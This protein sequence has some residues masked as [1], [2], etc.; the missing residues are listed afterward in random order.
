MRCKK[1]TLVLWLILIGSVGFGIYK[2]FTAIDIHTVHETE[3]IERQIV[4]TNKVES[5][6]E[7]F[8]KDLFSWQQSQE[9][10]FFD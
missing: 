2:N 8:A 7:S 3:I 4:D 5:F 1:L 9:A 10:L 6:V